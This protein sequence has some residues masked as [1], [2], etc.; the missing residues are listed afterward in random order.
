MYDSSIFMPTRTTWSDLLRPGDA[1][2]FFQRSPLPRFDPGLVSYDPGNAWWLAELS[3]LIYRHDVEEASRPSQ[4]TRS[5]FLASVGLRQRAFFQSPEMGTQAFLVES[6]GDKRFAALVF[7]G[8]E[9]DPRDVLRNLTTFPT[10]V[11]ASEIRVHEGFEE[12]LESV[13]SSVSRYLGQL[14]CPMFYAGHSLGA[15]LAT[16]AAR[17]RPPHAVYTFGSPR[18]G[19]QAFASALGAA[20]VYRV[21]NGADVVTT[22]PP[23]SLGYRHTGELHQIGPSPLEPRGSV[24]WW[25]SLH[26]LFGPPQPLAD[27]APINYVDRIR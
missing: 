19:N 4:P 13:W 8:T 2:S 3:R 25:T 18:V 20:A 21:V 1:T 26:L 27:H 16:L 22:L 9:Q 7:R 24:S 5:S 17:R 15:A 11:A 23:E 14:E 6:T 10:Q 12:A